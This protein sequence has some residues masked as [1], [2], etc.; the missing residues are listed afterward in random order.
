[1][2]ISKLLNGFK[3]KGICPE[4]HKQFADASTALRH[5]K[6]VHFPPFICKYCTKSLRILGRPETLK[7]HYSKCKQFLQSLN[8]DQLQFSNELAN[9][10]ALTSYTELKAM[11][12]VNKKT[13][14]SFSLVSS[15]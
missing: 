6:H 1:M 13:K 4:C 8:T 12:R 14:K 9:Q 3:V 7:S 2:N 15:Q 11:Y 10:I 5:Y